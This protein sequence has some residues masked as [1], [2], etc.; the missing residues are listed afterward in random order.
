MKCPERR[1]VR[2]TLASVCALLAVVFA[3]AARMERFAGPSASTATH[4]TITK[5]L[6]FTIAWL[7]IGY[8]LYR[9][10]PWPRLALAV[11]VAGP[12]VASLACLWWWASILIRT[13]VGPTAILWTSMALLAAAVAAGTALSALTTTETESSRWFAVG[14][15][16]VVPIA[17]AAAFLALPPTHLPGHL[18]TSGGVGAGPD[19]RDLSEQTEVVWVRT[20]PERVSRVL[21]TDSGPVVV[22][23]NTAQLLDPASGET[24]WSYSRGSADSPIQ[25]WG[26]SV[27]NQGSTV[28]LNFVVRTSYHERFD[29]Y[30]QT[31][32][33]DAATGNTL[34]WQDERL[35]S[36]PV[37][38]YLA[39]TSVRQAEQSP[40]IEVTFDSTG[41][42]FTVPIDDACLPAQPAIH[43]GVYDAGSMYVL[44]VTLSTTNSAET[45]NHCDGHTLIYGLH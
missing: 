43:G 8:R 44:D 19:K 30:T 15:G 18:T 1:T 6:L 31:V 20:M 38:N 37:Y 25:M 32:L 10:L 35:P 33:L 24:V 40:T 22:T 3:I 17:L 11:T 41:N 21:A 26:A 5:I 13:T 7:A 14:L 42:S 34:G 28:A 27:T 9:R 45:A 39:D 2:T 12:A 16:I 29:V 4:A 36:D 23:S